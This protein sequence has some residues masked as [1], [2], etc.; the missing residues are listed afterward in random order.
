MNHQLQPIP[1]HQDTIFVINHDDEPFVPVRPIC[2]N[3]GLDWASQFIKIKAKRKRFSVVNTTTQLPGDQQRREVVCI[4]LRKI[5][6]WLYSISPDKVAPHLKEK[7]EIYQEE[8]DQVLWNYWTKGIGVTDRVLAENIIVP[9]KKYVDLI[10]EN[11]NF[12]RKLLEHE[13]TRPRKRK[14]FTQEED[15][16]VVE[17]RSQGLSQRE[18]G[19]RIGRVKGS[20]ASCLRRLGVQ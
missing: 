4:H 16:M 5:T 1:F 11:N 19:K 14:N 18:I 10:E 20:V 9:T 15:A 17:L 8:C 3:M 2:E 6:A 13:K 12:L 7:I